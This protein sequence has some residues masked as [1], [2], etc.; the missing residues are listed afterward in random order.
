MSRNLRIGVY[1]AAR[2]G[3]NGLRT[4]FGSTYVFMEYHWDN[5]PPHGT[6][7]AVRELPETL[8]D[9][10]T[11]NSDR[12]TECSEC[13]GDIEYVPESYEKVDADGKRRQ[14]P[15]YWR[16]VG[17]SG[18]HGEHGDRWTPMMK[19]NE[20]LHKWLAGLE[21]KYLEPEGEYND[22]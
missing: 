10:I 20:R 18:A 16:Q 19:Y 4:K 1:D 7:T 15:G 5:G 17:T 11:I 2:G 9:D 12:G 14:V 21:S 13:H 6:A 8:P 3:F 22:L